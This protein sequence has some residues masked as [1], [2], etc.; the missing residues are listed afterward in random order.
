YEKEIRR[1]ICISGE[2]NLICEYCSC[3]LSGQNQDMNNL[4]TFQSM[5]KFHIKI[6]ARD[7]TSTTLAYQ[8]TMIDRDLFLQI[9]VS[10]LGLIIYQKYHLKEKSFLYP[11]ASLHNGTPCISALISFSHRI[12]CLVSSAVLE[13][14]SIKERARSVVHFINI[15]HKCFQLQNFQSCRSIL[16][17]LQSPSIFRLRETWK[18][19]KRKNYNKYQ[20][21]RHLCRFYINVQMTGYSCISKN[22]RRIPFLPCINFIL[23]YLQ[24]TKSNVEMVHE[25]YIAKA[26]KG[27]EQKIE[28]DIQ[29]AVGGDVKRWRKEPDLLNNE[30]AERNVPKAHRS[31]LIG[32]LST[33]FRINR[34]QKI[35]K[36]RFSG[37][38][39]T[40]SEQSPKA[41]MDN[42]SKGKSNDCFSL[43]DM[44]DN[45]LKLYFSSVG[46][47][48]SSSE[49]L[50]QEKHSNFYREVGYTHEC[51]HE[52]R[53][54]IFKKTAETL[55]SSQYC[56]YNYALPQSDLAKEYILKAKYKDHIQ[57][58]KLSLQVE[59][60]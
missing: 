34:T 55:I 19:V 5:L 3:K 28:M 39:D 52:N 14:E 16:F 33:V 22:S 7:F 53:M 17:G 56:A 8:L 41:A 29:N 60:S 47:D 49:I 42:Y 15:A 37:T 9:P 31:K 58:Y 11:F 50:D 32:F 38:V 12:S 13:G 6:F 2:E 10:E 25:S 4:T 48:W 27:S 36:R 40:L 18:Y 30:D 44:N 24:E 1:K 20:T 26:S 21:F 45:T 43:T 59:N 51:V 57:N 54:E 23:N 46:K 35:S